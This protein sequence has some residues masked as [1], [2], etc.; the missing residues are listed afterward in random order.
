L[1]RWVLEVDSMLSGASGLIE[2]VE[3]QG[4]KL[5]P[6]RTDRNEGRLGA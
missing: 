5:P 2:G 4:C 6:D 3:Q 1:E